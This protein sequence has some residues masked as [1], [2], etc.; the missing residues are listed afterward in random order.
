[1]SCFVVNG[2][3]ITDESGKEGP[4]WAGKLEGVKAESEGS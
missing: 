1:M 2:H 3:F 4:L